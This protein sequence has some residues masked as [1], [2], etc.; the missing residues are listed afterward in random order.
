MTM[1][2]EEMTIVFGRQR[3]SDVHLAGDVVPIE[4]EM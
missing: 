1:P 4:D 3:F 2:H